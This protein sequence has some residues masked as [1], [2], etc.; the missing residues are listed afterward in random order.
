MIAMG[1][2]TNHWFH[3]DAIYRTLPDAR[4]AR[5]AARAGTAAAGRTTSARRRCGRSTGWQSVAFALDWVRPPRH[6]SGTPWFYLA[7]DQWRYEGVRPEDLAWQGGRGLFRGKHV[8]DLNALGARLGWLP[9]HPAFDRNPLDLV[10]E[11]ERAGVEPAEYVVRELQEGRLG[12]ACEDPDAPE[13]IPRVLTVWRANILGSSGKGHEYFLQAPARHG[14]SRA[15]AR[16][17]RPRGCGRP[18][19]SGA[20][21]RRRGSSTC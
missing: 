1:A 6:Q 2:G 12:F 14:R 4:A 20:T 11:A 3:S 16:T 18:T 10:D 13:N 9:S 5:A 17:R 7:T 8:A 15:C 19:S 21:R